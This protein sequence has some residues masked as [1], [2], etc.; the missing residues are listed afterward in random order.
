MLDIFYHSTTTK[1][2]LAFETLFNNIS[3][4]R[5]DSSGNVIQTIKV[6]IAQSVR[7]KY[8]AREAQN[9]TLNEEKQIILPRLAY[10]ITDISYDPTRAKNRHNLITKIT[11]DEDRLSYQYQSV[12]YN[13]GITLTSL[14]RNSDDTFQIMEQILPYFTPDFTVKMN[15]IPALD[16]QKSI[17]VI[18][19]SITPTFEYDGAF[20]DTRKHSSVDFSFTLK[21]DYYGPIHE[22]G[23]IKKTITQL[24]SNL[25]VIPDDVTSNVLSNAVS[26]ITNTVDPLSANANSNYE[27][28]TEVIENNEN[29]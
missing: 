7:E 5:F 25:Q 10:E 26:R 19:N 6:P 16:I 23:V 17:P 27:I 15:V 11:T 21:I 12:P 9:P 1:T 24:Y 3:I 14:A 8:L 28:I 29:S 22:Q 20:E 4:R 18:L 13:L 2:L